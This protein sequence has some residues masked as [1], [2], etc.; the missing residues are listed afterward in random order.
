M[1]TKQVEELVG[2]SRQNIR[3]YEK[4]GL[5]TPCREQGNSYRDYSQ[6]DVERLKLIK[7]L[8]MLDMPL[9]DIALAEIEVFIPYNAVKCSWDNHIVSFGPMNVG[10]TTF[11][12][13]N[14]TIDEFLEKWNRQ[15]FAEELEVT[16]YDKGYTEFE[17]EIESRKMMSNIFL[18]SGLLLSVI[19][20]I[21]FCNLF[22]MG[23]RQRI[24][25]ERILGLSKRECFR[26]SLAGLLL[27]ATAGIGIGSVSGWLLTKQLSNTISYDT[28]YS[29]RMVQTAVN[30]SYGIINGSFWTAVS[31]MIILMILVLAIA[32]GYLK[33]VL[34]DTPL[35]M[36]GKLED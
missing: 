12:I 29:I 24:T 15:E 2:V 26:S 11:E 22:I 10:N 5:L 33:D 3:Y 21:F 17:R 16:F 34:K 35:T 31:S 9:K 30:D 27:I 28:L 13:E 8:R 32:G 4:E 25:V 20:L 14:G 1:N 23:Q 7:M 6:E 36:L 18:I 19:I